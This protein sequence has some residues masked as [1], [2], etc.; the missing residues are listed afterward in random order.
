MRFPA[1]QVRSVHEG[2]VPRRP[3]H[4][5]PS[6]QRPKYG[7]GVPTWVST[8]HGNFPCVDSKVGGMELPLDSKRLEQGF[9]LIYPGFPSFCGLGLED[10]RVP[11]KC[12]VAS[13]PPLRA[14]REAP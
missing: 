12:D 5:G 7:P 3:A 6:T 1:Y 4:E 14:Q 2:D 13:G 8:S 11:L 9:G 10:G